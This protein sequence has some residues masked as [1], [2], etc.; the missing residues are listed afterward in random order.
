MIPLDDE[1]ADV[2]FSVAVIPEIPDPVQALKQI[3]R[4]LK[5]EGIFAESELLLD[6][7]YPLQRTV[8][9]WARKAGFEFYN[10]SGGFLSYALV[11]VKPPPL[12]S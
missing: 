10:K 12:P 9:K 2:A 6:P 1:I 11:F 8:K 7:D 3:K 5:S 4:L